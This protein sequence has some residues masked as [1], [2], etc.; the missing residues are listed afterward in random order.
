MNLLEGEWSGRTVAIGEAAMPVG[1]PAET[2][3]RVTLGVR[4]GDLRIAAAGIAA[5][6]ERVED[7]GDSCIVIARV[8]GVPVKL[9][10]DRAPDL[11]DGSA[12]YLAFAAEHAHLFDPDSDDR[13]S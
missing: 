9:K 13:L 12:V 11:R 10:T 5:T 3:R 8:G 7:L 1:V 4:P 6:V 2:P